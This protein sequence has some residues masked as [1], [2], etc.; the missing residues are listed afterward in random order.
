MGAR[1]GAAITEPEFE[2]NIFTNAGALKKYIRLRNSDAGQPS[3]PVPTESACLDL[4]QF[5]RIIGPDALNPADTPNWHNINVPGGGAGWVN[6]NA[7]GI[8]KFSDADFPHWKHWTF[9]NETVGDD[10]RCDDRY[11]RNLIDGD[12]DGQLSET[13]ANPINFSQSALAQFAKIV[14]RFPTEWNA[15]DLITRWSW[16]KTTSPENPNPLN[17]VNFARFLDH[18]RSLCFWDASLGI[19][20]VHWHLPPKATIDHCKKCAWLS[21]FELAQCIPR[22]CILGAT[23]WNSANT[24]A[25]NHRI[26]LNKMLRK[27][28]LAT[29]TRIIHMLAQIFIETGL[30][31]LVVEGGSGAGHAYAAFFGRGFMQ[32]TWPRNFENYGNYRALPNHT[33]TYAD[34][35]ITATSTHIWDSGSPAQVWS[36]RYDPDLVGTNMYA[37]ADSG[38]FYWVSKTFRGTS[39]I[40]RAADIGLET[41]VVGFISWL[42][43]GGGN[44]Y[45]DRQEYAR[46]LHN[47][48]HDEPLRSGRENWTFQR[49]GRSITSSFP[50]GT[51]TATANV[52]INYATQRP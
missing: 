43:N 38:G 4:L 31:R 19:T 11:L 14:A 2:Y 36:P 1:Q 15:A 20:S 24:R 8:F 26:G 48:L 5:G 46:Y 18:A 44:G 42:V 6:L 23:S 49:L 33:G 21:A 39:N 34:A 27:Y 7:A 10:S 51:N 22:Q 50:P 45:N 13:E 3:N 30:L 52:N 41:N 32:L 25:T 28:G 40:N 17:D 47:L 9:I 37:A 16:L 35:R 29:D 12:G